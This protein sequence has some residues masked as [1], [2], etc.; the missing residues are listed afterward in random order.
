MD[1]IVSALISLNSFEIEIQET[2][3]RSVTALALV[4]AVESLVGFEF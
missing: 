4:N 3:H 2:K 1:T